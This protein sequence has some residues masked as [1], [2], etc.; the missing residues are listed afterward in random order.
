MQDRRIPFDRG[1][2]THEALVLA[3][4]SSDQTHEPAAHLNPSLGGVARSSLGLD[5][6]HRGNVYANMDWKIEFCECFEV[7]VLIP[8]KSPRINS[9]ERHHASDDAQEAVRKDM[10]VK[11]GGL[12]GGTRARREGRIRSTL[13]GQGR[14]LV[15]VDVIWVAVPANWIEGYNDVRFQVSDVSDYPRGHLLHRM[16]DLSIR[17][18]VIGLSFHARVP[19]SKK[20]NGRQSELLRRTAQLRFAQVCHR[21]VTYKMLRI[22]GS[23]FA[24][25]GTKK[26]HLVPPSRV[27]GERAS[28]AK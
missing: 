23:G 21:S 4:H 3:H 1:I 19:V 5:F 11:G 17:V 16:S 13:E 20:V 25:R 8:P 26:E 9:K 6:C 7:N 27:Q 22:D 2:C 24:A 18:L 15:D 28:H 10:V 12:E 14:C